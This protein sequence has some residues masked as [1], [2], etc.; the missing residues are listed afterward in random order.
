MMSARRIHQTLAI[1]MLATTAL[2]AV[3]PAAEAGHHGRRYKGDR[4]RWDRHDRHVQRVVVRDSGAGPALAGLIGGFILGTAVSSHAQPVVVRQHDCA[5][6]PRYR[7]YDPYCDE[8]FVSLTSAREHCSYDRH[9]W[10]VKVY[11]E[12]GGA[13]VR[14]MRWSDG[15]WYDCD[16]HDYDDEDWRD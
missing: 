11:D 2:L 5:P 6:A 16:D 1:A 9:P 15:A 7:Y 12:R 10:R 4:W 13:C 8:W 3:A 14:T